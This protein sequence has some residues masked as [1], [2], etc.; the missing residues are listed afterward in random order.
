[1][2]STQLNFDVAYPYIEREFYFTTD[3]STTIVPGTG[4]Q[5]L[6]DVN[7]ASFKVR[8]PDRTLARPT[9]A[10]TW[11]AD[12]QTQRF[13]AAN[14]A[15][16]YNDYQIAPILPGRYGIV[17]SA[18]TK[19]KPTSVP[20]NMANALITAIGRIV[21]PSSFANEPDTP[22][23]T[24][25]DNLAETRR[26]EMRPDT[27]GNPATP[28]AP[29]VNQFLVTHNGGFDPA[30]APPR[31]PADASVRLARR[32]SEIGRSNELIAAQGV[33][34]IHDTLPINNPPR[35]DGVPDS[36]H[37]QAC[38][39]VPVEGMSVSEPAWGWAPREWEAHQEENERRP[40]GTSPFPVFKPT[41]ANGEGRYAPPGSTIG[42]TNTTYFDVP[43]DLYR[44]EL[45][46]TG[47][48]A[49]YRTIH[50]Q[51]LADPLVPWNPPPGQVKDATGKDMHKPNLPIN[52][53]RTVDSSSVDLTAFN[54]V[55]DAEGSYPTEPIGVTARDQ[56]HDFGQFRPWKRN[57]REPFSGNSYKS[58]MNPPAP[59]PNPF[60]PRDPIVLQVWNFKSVERGGWNH[61]N[62]TQPA[63]PPF[64]AR[65]IW[66]QEPAHV[67]M[68]SHADRTKLI[69]GRRL[70][71]MRRAMSSPPEP[72][73]NY[74]P[75]QLSIDLGLKEHRV[76]MVLEH[77]LGFANE[78]SGRLFTQQ[79]GPDQTPTLAAAG[80]PK[81]YAYTDANDKTIDVTSTYPWLTWNSRPWVSAK[82][83]LQVP[84]ASSAEVFRLYSTIDRNA[85]PPGNG[86]PSD[87]PYTNDGYNGIAVASNPATGILDTIIANY[88]ASNPLGHLVDVF[89]AAA[90]RPDVNDADG[91]NDKGEPI[92]A[93]APHF[94]RILEYVQVPSRYVGTQTLLNP[95]IYNDVFGAQDGVDA[96]TVGS[97]IANVNDPR[98]NFQPPFNQV[99]RERDP[100]RVNLN[101]VTGQRALDAAGVPRIWSDVF[102]GIMHRYRDG[103]LRDGSGTLLQLGHAGPAWR[104]VA[105]SRRGYLE[106]STLPLQ[107]TPPPMPLTTSDRTPDNI[108]P[109]FASA[110]LRRDFP[111]IFA[112]PFRAPEA[113]DLVP[114]A[115]MMQ[116]G[117]QVGLLRA[118]PYAPADD[119]AKLDAG[120]GR[121]IDDA[122]TVGVD[123]RD[124]NNDGLVDD[125]REAGIRPPGED[126]KSSI[127]YAN[128]DIPVNTPSPVPLFSEA[129]RNSFTDPDRNP[130]TMYEPM[131]RLDNLVTNRSGVFAVW[132]TV[133]YFE[134]EKAPDWSSNE[135][136]AQDRFGGNTPESLSL[137]NRVYPDGYM[138]GRELG[139]DT[140]DVKRP[141]GFYII[142]RTE[143]VG[144]KPGEDL[145][146]ERTIRLRRRIE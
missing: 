27:D 23:D 40:S 103:D 29:N 54:G 135:N 65:T 132:V 83:I 4:V 134:V 122:S 115:N 121:D 75:T 93:V 141:R 46:R 125:A 69:D 85:P 16:E 25:V 81:A 20:A 56:Q 50:L 78:S 68:R 26:I 145:N 139:S 111:T 94:Y 31:D 100:G 137:Y 79:P 71:S 118:H 105:L 12:F 11:P 7:D 70:A 126:P 43:F 74:V 48:T 39:A 6:R 22:D 127:A 19:Y 90:Q 8:I 64:P 102:D 92:P 124:D 61:L 77:S 108:Y 67:E 13:I 123:E 18:G 89:A 131:S 143:E 84:A 36:V 76:D 109:D 86:K 51:R 33:K 41:E 95:D 114:L 63:R 97:D 140:G 9:I 14:S 35:P 101:T 142:D 15:D 88:R 138:L 99:S 120:W 117:V 32:A 10:G 129:A 106:A 107:P 38:V 34:N 66:A 53:Y 113:G 128:D 5:P 104:D 49:N 144:F 52:P 3:N 42:S 60:T 96:G 28:S 80:A 112:N 98:Y 73:K 59:P 110:L 45:N 24:H 58:H 55:S 2:S 91:D 1:M 47:T 44:A 21:P 146:V 57:E 116:T 87:N 130:Y 136:G 62:L 119:P 82:E 72:D 133:G 37:Y 30:N 17:G